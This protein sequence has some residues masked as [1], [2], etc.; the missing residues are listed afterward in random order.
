MTK[1]HLEICNEKFTH[2]I[3]IY[4]IH[5]RVRTEKNFF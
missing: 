1:M 3:N 5:Q 2:I 4:A